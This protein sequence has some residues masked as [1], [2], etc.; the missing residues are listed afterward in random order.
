[1]S[2]PPAPSPAKSSAP[3]IT[4]EGDGY[5]PAAHEGFAIGGYLQADYLHSQASDDQLSQSGAPIN[6]NR[7]YLRR[8]RL[9]VD[10]GF[11]YAAATLELD[12]NTIS[13][14]DVGI[15]LAEASLFYRGAN[16]VTVPPIVMLTAGITDLPFGFE[17][18]ESDRS[19]TFMERSLASSA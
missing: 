15:R 12:A 10:Q 4:I 2:P 13:G 6:L 11:K 17:L 5:S 18:T 3:L 19:R 9:R 16:P 7:F 1:K 14:V 8:G